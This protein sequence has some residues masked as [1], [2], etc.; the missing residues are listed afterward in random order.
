MAQQRLLAAA[1]QSAG[2]P[3]FHTRKLVTC[4]L[5]FKKL[6]MHLE[7]GV[8]KSVLVSV[9]VSVLE[10][11]LEKVFVTVSVTRVSPGSYP[12]PYTRMAPCLPFEADSER[13]VSEHVLRDLFAAVESAAERYAR[14]FKQGRRFWNVLPLFIFAAKQIHTHIF[15][16]RRLDDYKAKYKP[17]FVVRTVINCIDRSTNGIHDIAGDETRHLASSPD[18]LNVG[19]Q[20]LLVNLVARPRQI[21]PFDH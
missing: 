18:H 9:Q 5:F 13:D 7:L 3:G 6:L 12:R 14:G 15:Q 20:I 16:F 10:K 2:F 19:G 8:Q 17:R 11:V 1:G 4:S 21:R